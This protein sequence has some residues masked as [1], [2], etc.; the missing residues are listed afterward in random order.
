MCLSG[1]TKL[2]FSALELSSPCAKQ[3]MKRDSRM[4]Q[5]S[6]LLNCRNED[7]NEGMDAMSWLL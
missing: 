4:T 6:S 5:S 2:L 1:R 7:L 3:G